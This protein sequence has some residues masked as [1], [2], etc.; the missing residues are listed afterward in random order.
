MEWRDR[1]ETDPEVLAGKPVVAGTRIPVE[2]VVELLAQDW[3]TEEILE[4]YPA[5]SR[6]D[7]RASLHYA[8]ETLQSERVY[9][10]KTTPES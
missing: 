8:S 6:E 5:L 7:I 3:S 1:I 9:P 10:V 2:L 4:Q